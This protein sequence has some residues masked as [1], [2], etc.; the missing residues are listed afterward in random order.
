MFVPLSPRERTPV[1]RSDTFSGSGKLALPFPSGRL[2]S[3]WSMTSASAETV[4]PGE[5]RVRETK[6]V[7]GTLQ[8]LKGASLVA[9]FI[10]FVVVVQVHVLVLR[11]I[12]KRFR[13]MLLVRHQSAN[14]GQVSDMDDIPA[15]AAYVILK[16]MSPA[17]AREIQGRRVLHTPHSERKRSL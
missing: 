8:N 12:I 2:A 7:L 4:L 3:S 17:N 13:M 16:I 6:T 5:T 9:F 15:K 11:D 10:G 1:D 14:M